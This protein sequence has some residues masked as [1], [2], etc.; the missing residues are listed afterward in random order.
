MLI[1]Y[2]S[3]CFSGPRLDLLPSE[4]QPGAVDRAQTGG[5]WVHSYGWKPH[6]WWSKY[7]KIMEHLL[8]ITI[9]NDKNLWKTMV[10]GRFSPQS[11]E[12][13]EDLWIGLFLL[14]KSSGYGCLAFFFRWEI[15]WSSKALTQFF[16]EF[17]AWNVTYKNDFCRSKPQNTETL[18]T[19]QVDLTWFIPPGDEKAVSPAFHPEKL[20]PLQ[21]ETSNRSPFHP[22]ELVDSPWYQM[23]S[24]DLQV[25]RDQ[26][27]WMHHLQL[28]T[29]SFDRLEE[30]HEESIWQMRL[31]AKWE[32]GQGDGGGG[33]WFLFL[34][35]DW[36]LMMYLDMIWYD[37]Y[38]FCDIG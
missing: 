27:R 24:T 38:T 7:E 2:I 28:L 15:R 37:M 23:I 8:E 14:H 25:V 17:F 16:V 29:Q 1:L 19:E 22:N 26:T 21:P 9:L 18:L 30:A 6:I 33:C 11:A 34:I 32:T 4:A 35:D 31:A 20:E 5:A 13:H 10:S 3:R 12:I 36:W